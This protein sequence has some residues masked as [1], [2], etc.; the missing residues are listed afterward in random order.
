MPLFHKP[1]NLITILF[2]IL[3]GLFTFNKS[4]QNKYL[5]PS[6][7]PYKI[8]PFIILF[9]IFLPIIIAD[10]SGRAIKNLELRDRPWVD[11]DSDKVNCLVCKKNKE[12]PNLYLKK[13][14]GAHKSFPSNHAANSFA[15][16]F[17]ISFFFPK[18]K[19]GAYILAFIILFS[20]VY[21]GVHYPFDVIYGMCIGILCG[22]LA[23][24]IFNLYINKKLIR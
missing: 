3:I 6:L 21:I 19:I 15:I 13:G 23:T 7:I 24:L 10:Q 12:N 14:K 4:L 8:N 20:R 1:F 17:I 11:Q 16:A 18:L 22:Y 9:F 5:N 2:L